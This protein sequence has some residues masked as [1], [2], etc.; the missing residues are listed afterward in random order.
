MSATGNNQ[1]TPVPAAT[2]SRQQI[3][4]PAT[5]AEV[6]EEA[7]RQQLLREQEEKIPVIPTEPDMEAAAAAAAAARARS[8]QE[9]LPTMTATS[10]PGQ[11]WNPYGDGG[12]DEWE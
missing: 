5:S 10:Y 3:P 7:K 6:Y 11:E 1:R 8:E 12:F 9:E 2:P 4:A